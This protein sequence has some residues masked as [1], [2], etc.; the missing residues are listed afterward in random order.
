VGTAAKWFC[1]QISDLIITAR[2]PC[3][4]LC[5][6]E[7]TVTLGKSPGKGG[8]NQEFAALCGHQLARFANVAL[9]SCGTDGTD[10]PTDAAGAFADGTT[11]ERARTAGLDLDQAILS[12]NSYIFFEKLGDLIKT[13]PTGTN[14]MDLQIALINP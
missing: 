14:V 10:G 9:L 5:G 7:T 8:R 2:R 13:G 1:D 6:G 3:C 4:L 11:V 12:H